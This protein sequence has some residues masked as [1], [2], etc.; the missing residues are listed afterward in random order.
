MFRYLL[1]EMGMDS[2]GIMG[3]LERRP[4]LLGLDPTLNMRKARPGRASPMGNF[5]HCP[6]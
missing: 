1:D 2:A 3:A 4:N 5:A 6:L